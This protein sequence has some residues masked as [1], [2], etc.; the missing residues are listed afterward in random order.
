[1]KMFLLSFLNWGKFHLK[2]NEAT[3][4]SGYISDDG[5]HDSDRGYR[6]EETEIAIQKSWN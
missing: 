3:E 2:V 4:L 1:M 6:D 5:S